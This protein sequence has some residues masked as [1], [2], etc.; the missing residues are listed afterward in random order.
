MDRRL[1]A[2]LA[3]DVV[4]YSRMMAADERGT[5]ERLRTMREEIFDPCVARHNGR[6]VKLMGDGALIEFA[7]VVDAVTC[8][9]QIQE[10]LDRTSRS[11]APEQRLDLRIGI[12]LGDVIADGDDIYGDGVNI[13]AR[14]EGVAD[15]GGIC[16][17][18]AV[19]EQVAQKTPFVYE[20]L[21]LRHLKNIDEPVAVYRVVSETSAPR[22]A[23]RQHQRSK[24][25]RPLLISALLVLFALSAWWTWSM[26]LFQFGQDRSLPK[27][28]SIA[29][30][31]F[32][33]LS[34]E[35]QVWFGDGMA[36]DIITDLS[37]LPGL[38]VIARNSSFQFR[39]GNHDMRT[40][41]EQLGVAYLLEGSV[42]RAGQTLR[43]NAQLIDASSGGHVWADR[44]DGAAADVFALQDSVTEQ[45]VRNMRVALLSPDN[46][47]Q[48]ES[49]DPPAAQPNKDPKRD[50]ALIDRP[51]PIL[52]EAHDAYLRAMGHLHKRSPEDFLQAKQ[53]LDQAI[54]IS[55]A[56]PR[57]LAARAS[58][59]L[60]T[61]E[62]GWTAQVDVPSTY[63]TVTSAAR[64]AMEHPSALAHAVAA[65]LYAKKPNPEAAWKQVELGLALDPNE[66]EL[67]VVGALILAGRDD[68]ESAWFYMEQAMRLNPLAPAHFHQAA[69]ILHFAQGNGASALESY[70]RALEAEDQNWILRL[71]RAAVLA[72]L[73]RVQEA[74]TE[75]VSVKEHYDAQE[76]HSHYAAPNLAWQ[77]GKRINQAYVDRLAAAFRAAGI[78]DI[79]KGHALQADQRLT[80]EEIRQDV[81]IRLIGRCCGGEWRVDRPKTGAETYFWDGV[82]LFTRQRTILQ[83]GSVT[84]RKQDRFAPDEFCRVYRNPGGADATFDSR[85]AACNH[86]VFKYGVFPLDTAD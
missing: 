76:W 70:D 52:P 62:R 54:S 85:F 72:D 30:L 2:I 21:G 44:F 74:A 13:A 12:N 22:P 10:T 61:Y 8:A 26:G 51:E 43:I 41:G 60:E 86:G 49:P 73:G 4:G 17:S 71:E 33:D 69:G 18:Q 35:P 67:Y 78:P 19:V 64:A 65:D 15:P 5:L 1:A 77:N 6:L 40:V 82:P 81:D 83:D 42:R 55:P 7:S 56:Y 20:G 34:A 38:F 11:A 75:L 39:G 48:D 14:L 57:A 68:F 63:N 53:W 80:A 79:P 28:P 66:S 47:N 27:Q 23:P 16:L 36:E 31:P 84:I 46:D 29:V 50:P 59:F 37:K 3:A 25:R 32:Q 24:S 58:L 9:V 45:V